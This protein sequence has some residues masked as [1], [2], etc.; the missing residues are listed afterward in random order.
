MRRTPKF[1]KRRWYH[2]MPKYHPCR[3][4]K[5]RQ[6]VESPLLYL[7]FLPSAIH[8]RNSGIVRVVDIA[9]GRGVP[10]MPIL[11]VDQCRDVPHAQMLQRSATLAS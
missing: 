3:V 11:S 9:M 5:S 2:A 8:G 6:V 4:V 10:S 1:S 7:A